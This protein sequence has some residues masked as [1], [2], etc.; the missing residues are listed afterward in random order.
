MSSL[1]L[2]VSSSLWDSLA[3]KLLD[4]ID[5]LEILQKH[6][7]SPPCSQNMGV[8]VDRDAGTVSKDIHVQCATFCGSHDPLAAASHHPSGGR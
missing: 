1:P 7:A 5:E 8:V 6:W 2:R 3:I 4:L